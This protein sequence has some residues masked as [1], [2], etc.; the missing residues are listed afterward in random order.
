VTFR[1]GDAEG[2]LDRS[3]V[4][5]G[6]TYIQPSRHNNPM[7]PSAITAVWDGD[8]LTLYDSVQHV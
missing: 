1:K 5:A 7:E 6:G 8:A 4:R 2:E 3:P